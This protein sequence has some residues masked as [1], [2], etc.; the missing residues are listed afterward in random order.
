[1]NERGL[2]SQPASSLTD[3][4]LVVRPGLK[5]RDLST[6]RKTKQNKFSGTNQKPER[7][8]PFGTGLVRHCP[9]GLFWPFSTFF[10]ALFFRPFRLS[11]ASTICPWVSEDA[12]SWKTLLSFE[13]NV[14]FLGR[15]LPPGKKGT[16]QGGTLRKSVSVTALANQFEGKLTHSL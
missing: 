3:L 5:T 14:S 10:R 13:G 7:R 12:P 16:S 11:L 6:T 1:M 2:M 9:Q 8:R 4:D 15:K